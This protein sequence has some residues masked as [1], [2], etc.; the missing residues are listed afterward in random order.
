MPLTFAS[1]GH[2]RNTRR[3]RTKLR[4][5]EFDI[6][7]SFFIRF[8]YRNEDGDLEEAEKGFL[9]SDWIVRVRFFSFALNVDASIS[10]S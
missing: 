3:V 4:N 7:S 10:C 8:L 5:V 2:V 1:I 9:Y 6:N